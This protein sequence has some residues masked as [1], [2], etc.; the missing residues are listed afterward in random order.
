M[1]Q[2][3]LEVTDHM[4][5]QYAAQ[6]YLEKLHS[7]NE[8]MVLRE[9]EREVWSKLDL[10]HVISLGFLVSPSTNVIVTSKV[11]HYRRL[12]SYMLTRTFTAKK[13]K[14]LVIG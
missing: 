5:Q 4:E 13:K 8:A 10:L 7:E 2:I 3:L 1:K 9:K 14:Y 12:K 6:R 11:S